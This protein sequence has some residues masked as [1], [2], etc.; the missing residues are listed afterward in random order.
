M[1]YT[2]VLIFL[3]SFLKIKKKYHFDARVPNNI[4]NKNTTLPKKCHSRLKD[5]TCNPRCLVLKDFGGQLF[6]LHET[7]MGVWYKNS[8]HGSNYSL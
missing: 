7:L 5:G 2:L 4:K 1:Y 6:C 8:Y 3:F